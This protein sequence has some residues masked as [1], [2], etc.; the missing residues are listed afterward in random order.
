MTLILNSKHHPGFF[1]HLYGNQTL[2]IATNRNNR[3]GLLQ[4]ICGSQSCTNLGDR[5]NKG[6]LFHS[7]RSLIEYYYRNDLFN[8]PWC[9]PAKEPKLIKPP[10]LATPPTLTKPPQLTKPPMTTCLSLAKLGSFGYRQF[11]L[12]IAKFYLTVF[13]GVFD[14][15]I[16]LIL[17]LLIR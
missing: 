12:P 2:F 16:Q 15:F 11:I 9:E 8:T 13:V 7:M 10:Q 6:I 14:F 5:S 3:H 1:L 4:I 17:N